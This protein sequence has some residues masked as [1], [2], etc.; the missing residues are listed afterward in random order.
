[1]IH[2]VD[3]GVGNIGSIL[4]MLKRVGSEAILAS[5]S[6]DLKNATKIVLP[7][8]GNFDHGMRQ[9]K[10]SG[11]IELL[12]QKVNDEKVPILGIC[13]GAQLMC[14]ASEEG[15]VEGLSWFDAEVKKFN[16]NDST[17]LRIPHMGWN[18]VNN[19]KDSIISK[20]LPQDSRFYFVHSYHMVTK[21]TN[22]ILF[23]TN[24]GYDFVSGLQHE[25]KFACQFHPEKSHKYGIQMF[26]NFASI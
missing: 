5:T 15:R 10:K 17:N 8:V 25:N 21:H 19:V 13:L 1:M 3:Y 11:M 2:I 26:K 18:Y 20:D 16:F 22:D 24:Y 7:G 14:N 4:N 12:N 6:D 9:L 23:K